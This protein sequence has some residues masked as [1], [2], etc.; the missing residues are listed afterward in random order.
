MVV[1]FL[2]A[3]LNPDSCIF[4]MIASVKKDDFKTLNIEFLKKIFDRNQ[5]P[6][7]LLKDVHVV[8]IAHLKQI[9]VNIL[10]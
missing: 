6:E 5:Y 9:Q 1:S 3:I 4:S 10:H 8:F 2:A 7:T